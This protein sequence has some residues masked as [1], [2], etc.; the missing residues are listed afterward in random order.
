MSGY[1]YTGAADWGGK[2]PAKCNRGLYRLDTDTEAYPLPS[3]V[4]GV[5]ALACI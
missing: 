5:Y 1:V 3:G 4:E 2:D